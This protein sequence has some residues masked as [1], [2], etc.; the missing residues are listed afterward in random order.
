MT[1]DLQ[2]YTICNTLVKQTAQRRHPEVDGLK[3][4]RDLGGQVIYG[5]LHE[6]EI[7]TASPLNTRQDVANHIVLV[8]AKE[9]V[10]Q[11]VVILPPVLLRFSAFYSRKMFV[12]Q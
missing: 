4:W 5:K 3:R 11:F 6:P 2:Q 9:T 8:C 12:I 10:S 1:S 7:F